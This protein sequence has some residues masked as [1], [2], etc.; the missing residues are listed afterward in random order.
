M[1]DEFSFYSETEKKEQQNPDHSRKDLEYNPKVRWK[2][3]T[4]IVRVTREDIIG[5][6]RR[7]PNL[8]PFA[9]AVRRSGCLPGWLGR[10]TEVSCNGRYI[11]IF[12]GIRG[13]RQGTIT[14]WVLPKEA[15]EWCDRYDAG[16]EMEPINFMVKKER[17]GVW[18]GRT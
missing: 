16:E 9:R 17:P 8:D 4:E 15:R 18:R 6:T 13:T 12:D 1:H 11:R 10:T 5:A 2:G 14:L 7:H 3:G